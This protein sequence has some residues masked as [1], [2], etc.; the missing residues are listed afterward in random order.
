MNDPNPL[1]IP[2]NLGPF[3][4]A[5]LCIIINTH[6]SDPPHGYPLFVGYAVGLSYKVQVQTP[7][8]IVEVDNVTPCTPRW[9]YPK[10]VQ[11]FNPSSDAITG[12]P[13][14]VLPCAVLDGR[15]YLTCSELP[16]SGPCTPP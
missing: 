10:L 6:N 9:A 2:D 4:A 3:V 15:L 16:Y 11:G 14:Q 1:P 12:Q 8:G 7:N 13:A 5:G